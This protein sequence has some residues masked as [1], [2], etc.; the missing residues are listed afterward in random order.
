MN[1]SMEKSAEAL[2]QNHQQAIYQRTDRLFAALMVLQWLGGIAAALWI[3]P[4]AW[5]GQISQPHIHVWAALF[6]GGAITSLPVLLAWLWP[7][8]TITRHT[9]GISQM[10][11]GALLIHL[12]GGRIETHFHVFGSLAFLA[13]YRD[14]RVLVTASAVVAV[15]H[16]VR[17]LLWPESVFGVIS[18]GS[19]RWLEHAGWV[20]FEDMFLIQ[21]IRQS[22]QEMHG[23][24]KR[25]AQLLEI[26]DKIER[27]VQERTEELIQQTQKL[28]QGEAE[29]KRA[30]EAAEYSELRTR[31]I[32][33]NALDGVVTMNAEGLITGWNG[34]AE[35][36]FGWSAQEVIGRVLA[37]T[38]IP[39]QYR[40]AHT[41]GLRRFLSTGEG[42][43][44]NRR[45]EITALHRDGH[46]LPVE[47]AISP[48][49]FETTVTFSAFIRDITERKRSEEEQQKAKE[50][51][52]A[53]NRAKSEFL[54]NMSHEIR[55][56]MNGIIGMTE[57]AMDTD[58]TP[59]Q[60]EYLDAVKTSGESLLTIINDILDFSKIEACKLD[61][62][63]VDF[64]LRDILD[65]T[66]RALAVRAH[67]KGLE[68]ACQ[69]LPNVPNNL[70]GDPVR[71][72]QVITNL[73]GNAIKFTE[74]GEVVVKIEQKSGT[75]DA[76]E[77]HFSVS[78]T[79]IGIPLEKQTS[80]FEPFTQADGSTTRKYGGTGLGLTISSQLVGLMG[81]KMCVERQSLSFYRPLRRHRQSWQQH[82]PNERG[83]ECQGH[84]RAGGG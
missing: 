10:L 78:D 75:A 2:F 37:D 8:R 74:R 54:A 3:S 12:T 30:K 18:A 76:V 39:G 42:P 57:L 83:G 15:D 11:F 48:L 59:E 24:A 41:E 52:E 44:L 1:P 82:D 34:Q 62:E 68:L 33:D 71:V 81:G 58:L 4:R 55:T 56:P 23:M 16:F 22:V 31:M 84:A 64:K 40:Q 43:V 47:L 38:I 32:V 14:W 79:G 26:H 80:I 9:I 66:M 65:Q 69:I 60:R 19:L 73:V 27:T 7:G 5:A 35:G 29:L 63:S 6:L 51:A 13:I 25:Q 72:R 77:L 70:V 50:A 17:G 61:L 36:I 53:A 28:R 67:G 46:E 45:L 49:K 21:A 20:I